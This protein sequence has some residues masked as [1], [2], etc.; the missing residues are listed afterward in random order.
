[1]KIN[2]IKRNENP[3]AIIINLQKYLM[4][5][6]RY[7]RKATPVN[8]YAAGEIFTSKDCGKN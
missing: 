6:L 3:N 8:Y 2:F 7:R 4:K 1:M 5:T